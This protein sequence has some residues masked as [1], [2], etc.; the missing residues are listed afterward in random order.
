MLRMCVWVCVGGVLG[1]SDV[2]VCQW[3]Y[4]HTPPFSLVGL[5]LSLSVGGRMGDNVTGVNEGVLERI[6]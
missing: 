5:G 4:S 6:W 2:W 3:V 1:W